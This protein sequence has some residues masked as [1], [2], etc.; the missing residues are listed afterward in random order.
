MGGPRESQPRGQWVTVPTRQPC[1]GSPAAR[2]P[3]VIYLCLTVHSS[4]CQSLSSPISP[5]SSSHLL[6]LAPVLILFTGICDQG[7][8]D[9][10]T[11]HPDSVA[12]LTT[13]RPADVCCSVL[14][15]RDNYLSTLDLDL[16]FLALL[17][18]GGLARTRHPLS[19]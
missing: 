8:V 13:R 4:S 18:L 3:L 2:F 12:P 7:Q 17:S 15:Q 14:H 9:Q 5:Y 1:R 11:L 10:V 16:D 6:A 19:L